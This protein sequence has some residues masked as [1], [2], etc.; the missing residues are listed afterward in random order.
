MNFRS[1]L[2]VSS[3]LFSSLLPVAAFAQIT[4][5]PAAQPARVQEQLRIDTVRPDVGGAPLITMPDESGK[6]KPLKNAMTFTL[7]DIIVKNATAFSDAEIKAEYADRLGQKISLND[8]NAIAAKITA[9]YRNAGY[10]L[11]RAVVA[12]QRIKDGSA[13]ITIVEG[14][15]DNVIIEGTNADSDLLRS[16]GQKIKNAKPLNTETL[17]RY[18]LLIQDLP[19]VTARAVLRPSPTVSGASDVL[20]TVS[21]KTIDGTATFDNRGTRFIG[22]YQGGVTMNA[23]NMLG[24]HDRTQLRGTLSADPSELQFFQVSHDEQI[25]SE[26][27]KVTLSASHTRTQPNFRLKAFDIEGTDTLISASVLHPFLRS[28][29]TNLFGNASFDIRNTGSD[30]LNSTLYADRLKVG[31]VGGSYDFVDS[32][33]AV[34]RLDAQLSKGFGWDDDSGSGKRSRTNGRTDFWK[35]YAQASRLQ[36]ISGPFGVLL[37]S[38]GQMSSGALLSA[39]QFGL[40]GQQFLSAYD[41]SEVTGDS[42]IAGRIELQYSKAGEFEYLSAYQLYTF[43]DIGE[44]WTRNPAAG[45]KDS[46]SL[47]SAGLGVR[48]NILEPLSGSLEVAKPLTKD[49]NTNRPNNG[50]D[51]RVFFSLAYRY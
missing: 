15:V 46:V 35:F 51:T 40:G 44:I 26:G 49:V 37:S 24:I 30:S 14:F 7:T 29:Q 13:Q 3:F 32:F 39:E 18:L 34:N 36:T 4:S 9:K 48:F 43:Y 38:Q 8:L 27:T 31:R 25:G 5:T 1:S 6:E 10:I 21:Q 16:Y 41:P 17:E 50:D 11:S 47:A 20:I 23:N 33:T 12:P 22:P 28:R 42:G 2:H 19:G 45:L